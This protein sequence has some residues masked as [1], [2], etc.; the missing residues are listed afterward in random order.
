MRQNA[1]AQLKD[2]DVGVRMKKVRYDNDIVTR[3]LIDLQEA[4]VRLDL[5]RNKFQR[6]FPLIELSDEVD[7]ES[8]RR[9]TPLLFM[10][11]MSVTSPGIEGK[12][13]RPA[14]VSLYNQTTDCIM[15]ESMALGSKTLELLKCAILLTMWNNT[16]EIYHHQKIHFLTQLCIMLAI[17]LGLAG[18][19]GDTKSRPRF[20]QIAR[21]YVLPDPCTYECRRLWLSVYI[22]SINVS[23]VVKRPVLMIWSKYTEEC[24]A[25]LEKPDRPLSEHRLAAFARLYHLHEEIVTALHV[26]ARGLPDVNDPRTRCM[27][28][29][30]E[31]RLQ[32]LSRSVDLV[33]VPHSTAVFLIQ[34]HLHESVMYA[35]A[36]PRFGRVPFSEYGLVTGPLSATPHTQ[37]ALEW[38]YTSAAR[39]LEVVAGM[40]LTQLAVM[41]M[42]LFTR[43]AFCT[44]TLLKLRVLHLTNPSFSQLFSV[45]CAG[46]LVLVSSVLQRLELV[47]AQFPFAN[48]AVNFCF[49]LHV[50]VSHFERLVGIY[51]ESEE[52]NLEQE[53]G[54]KS[55]TAKLP[56][57]QQQP[58][59]Q[60]PSFL[61]GL[62]TFR[63]TKGQPS[64]LMDP[65]S[66]SSTM[67]FHP[68]LSNPTSTTTTATTTTAQHNPYQNYSLHAPIDHRRHSYSGMQPGSP[69]D[70]LSAVAM[71][72]HGMASTSNTANGG[73]SGG[74]GMM[75]RF[76]GQPRHVSDP[77][78]GAFHLPPL[79]SS[80]SSAA[81][82]GPE[83]A[84]QTGT[85]L[86]PDPDPGPGP[87]SSQD[88]TSAARQLPKPE[89]DPEHEPNDQSIES[90]Q[91]RDLEDEGGL[92]AY[93][94]W[95]TTD[96]FWKDLVPGIEALSGFD[97]YGI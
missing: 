22:S 20:E 10:T 7:V 79:S 95:L 15:Y 48:M 88:Q 3:G 11:V 53:Q 67:T 62:H 63:A 33:S 4:E 44:A 34:I 42:S 40:P 72:D 82:P 60:V 19:A 46:V 89:P 14:C 85:L 27:V 69:L 36:T 81:G 92:D 45:D 76:D 84:G 55:V 93:P 74:H 38:C 41:P 21:P 96:Y 94:G 54:P 24:C 5:F 18:H 64:L 6:E 12:D 58:P 32:V 2:I 68:P 65:P 87:S 70:I 59:T 1:A 50:L 57:L 73:G 56:P 77:V 71:G 91:A 66:L 61:E 13:R 83:V 97:L 80:S 75:N 17:D 78:S 49:V 43:L 39:A 31:H 16:P 26:E 30:F 9:E 90:H 35:T 52:D 47:M 86:K 23:M 51:G 28:R 25:M 37:K 8:M 29:Y